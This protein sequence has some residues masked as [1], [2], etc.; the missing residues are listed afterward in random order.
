MTLE[1]LDA[2]EQRGRRA[3]DRRPRG[4]YES[5]LEAG[6][7]VRSRANR[8]AGRAEQLEQAQHERRFDAF[9]LRSQGGVRIRR[10]GEL[11]RHLA[12]RL[13][14]HQLARA[15]LEVREEG[16]GIA[17]LLRA[18]LERRE[19]RAGVS[20]SDRVD[21]LFEHARVGDAQHRQH[22]LQGDLAPE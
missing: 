1:T 18:A 9:G 20:P 12:E 2:C 19:R 5:Q 21:R 22:V 3:V 8:L 10:E 11:A 7:R 17:A 4:L 14:D 16:G 15:P 13:H 6:A